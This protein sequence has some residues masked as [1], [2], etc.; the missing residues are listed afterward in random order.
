MAWAELQQLL[1][2]AVGLLAAAL[3]IGAR[4]GNAA[5]GAWRGD[6]YRIEGRFRLGGSHAVMSMRSSST[7]SEAP[8]AL[9]ACRRALIDCQQRVAHF[10]AQRNH[11]LRLVAAGARLAP[12]GSR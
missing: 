4:H 10:A 2:L 7:P 8:L 12:P 11:M 9:S 6:Q 1:A 5:I 3:G